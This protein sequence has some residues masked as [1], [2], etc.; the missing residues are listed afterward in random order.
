MKGLVTYHQITQVNLQYTPTTVFRISNR[1]RL[2]VEIAFIYETTRYCVSPLG[3]ST[4]IKLFI[5]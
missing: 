5:D 2:C 1:R 4:P 3:V